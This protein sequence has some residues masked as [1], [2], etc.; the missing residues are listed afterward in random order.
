MRV[1]TQGESC[2]I[3]LVNN[4]VNAPGCRGVHIL[5]GHNQLLALLI[6]IH[7]VFLLQ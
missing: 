6:Y 1:D 2:V 3:T 5:T 7:Y 4:D